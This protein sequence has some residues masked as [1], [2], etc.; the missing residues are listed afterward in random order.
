MNSPVQ[1]PT[2]LSGRSAGYNDK[3]KDQPRM[4]LNYNLLR[5]NIQPL[6]GCNL[7]I[8]FLATG[9][10]SLFYLLRGIFNDLN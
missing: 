10:Y 5:I 1:S 8:H 9:G 4:G 6:Q 7:L 3:N 2:I